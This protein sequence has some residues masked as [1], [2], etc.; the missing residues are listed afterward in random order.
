MQ[1]PAR[2]IHQSVEES[3]PLRPDEKINQQTRTGWKQFRSHV[4]LPCLWVSAHVDQTISRSKNAALEKL[5]KD[6]WHY[7]TADNIADAYREFLQKLLIRLNQ[8]LLRFKSTGFCFR[9][10]GTLERDLNDQV[11]RNLHY[12]FALWAPNNLFSTDP[13]LL[14]ATA[15]QCVSLWHQKVNDQET[16]HYKPIHIDIINTKQDSNHIASYEAKANSVTQAYEIFEDWS[17]AGCQSTIPCP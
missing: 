6:L 15:D 12:H 9:F 2:I 8:K 7:G 13:S 11:G 5:S 4:P 10:R 17:L 1:S 14:Q 3:I 16:D